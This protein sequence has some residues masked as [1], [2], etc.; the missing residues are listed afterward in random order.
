MIWYALIGQIDNWRRRRRRIAICWRV[1]EGPGKNIPNFPFL[2]HT[3][4]GPVIVDS[5]VH[6]K[7]TLLSE[8]L[9]CRT[10]RHLGFSR[11]WQWE[12]HKYNQTGLP[13]PITAQIFKRLPPSSWIAAC[14]QKHGSN[15]MF[16]SLIP[17]VH[18]EIYHFCVASQSHVIPP[19]WT[20]PPPFQKSECKTLLR[21]SRPI[22]L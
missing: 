19:K 21:I 3:L 8:H 22:I 16:C 10:W 7:C 11:F 1:T 2:T 13:Q 9:Y 20:A 6:M 12:H 17:Q 5:A 4:L 14:W 18:S 15:T